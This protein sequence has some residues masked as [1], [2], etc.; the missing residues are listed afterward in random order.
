MNRAMMRVL[1]GEIEK[2]TLR[3]RNSILDQ[4][5]LLLASV[6]GFST[7]AACYRNDG[8]LALALSD[9]KRALSKST[10]HSAQD[11][12]CDFCGIKT[13][14]L[15]ADPSCWPVWFGHPD[16]NNGA[17]VCH[18]AGCVS[19]AVFEPPLPQAAQRVIEAARKLRQVYPT[20]NHSDNVVLIG[21]LKDAVTAY[22]SELSQA[23][24]ERAPQS[25]PQPAQCTLCNDTGWI[26]TDGGR[27]QCEQCDARWL[28]SD[29]QREPLLEEAMKQLGVSDMQQFMDTTAA[30]ELQNADADSGRARRSL[31]EYLELVELGRKWR[32]DSSLATWFP[33]V[34]ADLD[35]LKKTVSTHAIVRGEH[36]EQFRILKETLK[37]KSE[38]LKLL[39]EE[40]VA[41]HQ[42]LDKLAAESCK[43]LASFNKAV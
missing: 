20:F 3:E 2:A 7:Q 18:C 19:K 16:S 35:L 26:Q 39:R 24:E 31:D 42:Q 8:G 41:M 29:E 21:V 13:D 4:L 11:G 12:L 23:A 43:L 40:R 38:E 30:V 17:T 28:L 25:Q 22:D 15:A 32:R 37:V 5:L 10:R 1:E 14:C 34:V 36:N 6:A 27:H 33:Q 9:L